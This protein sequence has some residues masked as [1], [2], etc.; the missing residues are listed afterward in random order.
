MSDWQL[1]GGQGHRP[2]P[3]PQPIPEPEPEPTEEPLFPVRP[4]GGP[5]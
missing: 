2:M 1:N 5:Q 3:T 4:V